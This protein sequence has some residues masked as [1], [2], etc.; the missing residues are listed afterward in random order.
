MQRTTR[1]KFLA[2]S[3]SAVSGA[4]LGPLLL[5]AERAFGALPPIRKTVGPMLATDPVLV[6][7]ANA[8]T[9]MKALP[10]TDPRSW[11]Y[12]ANMH[13]TTQTPLLTAWSTC[14]HHTD[15]FWSWHRMYLYWFE[16][17]VRKMAN[18]PGWAIPYW[19]WA[20]GSDLQVPAP[21]RDPASVLWADRNTAMNDGT[22][23]LNPLAVDV[24]PALS[25]TSY[26]PAHNAI[27]GPH[28]SVHVQVGGLMKSTV[29]AAQDP[30]FWVHHSNIDRLWTVWISQGGGR[31]NPVTD[32]AW[33]SK[34]FTFFDENGAAVT[35]NACQILNTGK[36][37][38][39][40][41]SKLEPVFASCPP[42]PVVPSPLHV[43]EIVFT[44]PIPPVELGAQPAS[45]PME[46][47]GVRGRLA[48]LLKSK[49][50]SLYLELDEVLAD[51][52]PG[53]TWAVFVGLPEGAPPSAKSPHF[54]GQLGLFG[55]GVRDEPHHG[56][57]GAHF[58]FPISRALRAAGPKG[59][60]LVSV[61]L[62]PL[63]MYRDG[64]PVTPEVKSTV[65][66][67]RVSVW[68]ERGSR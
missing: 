3:G 25:E 45:F 41:Y 61:R 55:A 46:L 65:R 6:S 18:D 17:I 56:G 11:S 40:A 22:G 30:L 13:G 43:K 57:E 15:F 47:K 28:D 59:L 37:L 4:L 32:S 39:Y 44:L 5:T 26:F 12:Q 58:S 8:I 64:K 68:V 2:A 21:F 49:T 7:Y 10:P 60:D 29:T 53:V 42:K 50:D 33:T 63:G 31:T 36:Q 48:P 16:R 23:S 24:G 52:Q 27:M 1:R 14:E 62:V 20:P 9:A 38:G 67:G 51:T 66:I 19:N 54:V 34:T 35:M